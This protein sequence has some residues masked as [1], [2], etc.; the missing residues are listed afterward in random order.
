MQTLWSL[1]HFRPFLETWVQNSISLCRTNNNVVMSRSWCQVLIWEGSREWWRRHRTGYAIPMGGRCHTE[2]RSGATIPPY[3]LRESKHH[4]LL[5]SPTFRFCFKFD[6]DWEKRNLK[7]QRRVEQREERNKC[8]TN[9]CVC[10][11]PVSTLALAHLLLSQIRKI[12]REKKHD[13]SVSGARTQVTFFLG[14]SF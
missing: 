12:Y 10:G 13:W 6:G 9:K 3:F 4:I 2:N 11:L 5:G 1:F 7:E 14:L 8:E